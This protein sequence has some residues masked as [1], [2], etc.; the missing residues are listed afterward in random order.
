MFWKTLDPPLLSQ[1][2]TGG[3]SAPNS[4]KKPVS[5]FPSISPQ[6][7]VPCTVIFHSAVGQSRAE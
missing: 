5:S 2:H 1:F 3:F 4:S 7:I 6:N